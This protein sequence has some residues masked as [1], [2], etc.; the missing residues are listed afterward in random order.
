VSLPQ[1]DTVTAYEELR[2]AVLSA[3]IAGCSGLG[4]LRRSGLA[5]WMRQEVADAE[6]SQIARSDQS[7]PDA[8]IA[9]QA[10]APNAL[11]GVM[12]GIILALAHGEGTCL[13]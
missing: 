7:P 3:E 6:Q 11:T 8:A 10:A 9:P 12:A 4:V 2:S 1:G 5:T 13:S